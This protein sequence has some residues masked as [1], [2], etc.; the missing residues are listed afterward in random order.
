MSNLASPFVLLVDSTVVKQKEE[1]MMAKKNW[2]KYYVNSG[3]HS[4][5][6]KLDLAKTNPHYNP[7]KRVLAWI[8]AKLLVIDARQLA[9]GHNIDNKF[10]STMRMIQMINYIHMHFVENGEKPSQNLKRECVIEV[11]LKD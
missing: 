5:C 10:R 8:F 6:A 11:Q 1:F 4:A 9:F 7:Y 3:N 2:Y